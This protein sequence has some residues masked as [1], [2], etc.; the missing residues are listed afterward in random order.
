[1][2]I[3]QNYYN[4]LG[5]T[6]DADTQE[7]NHAYRKLAFLYHPDRN[8]NDPEANEKMKEINEAYSTLVDIKKRRSYD[9]P[10][11]YSAIAPKFKTGNR[12]TINY[13]ST[14]PY[15]DHTGVIDKEPVKD[16]FRFWYM[17]RFEMTGFSTIVRFAE[18]ELSSVLE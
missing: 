4:L 1:M 2:Q 12:V 16:A 13:H 10:L 15:R 6:P 9:L 18:E 17:V 8:Q 11:G 5:I 7:I 3:T 14:S